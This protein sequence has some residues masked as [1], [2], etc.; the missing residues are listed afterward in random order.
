ME[1]EMAAKPDVPV[2]RV[3]ERQ[4]AQTHALILESARYLFDTNGFEKTTIRAVATHA[5][6]GLGTLYK[7]FTNKTSLLAAALYDDLERLFQK[8]TATIPS[9]GTLSEQ[10]LHMA[11]FTYRYYTSRPRLSREYLKNIVFVEDEWADKIE[12]FDRAFAE[13]VTSLSLAARERGEI[14]PEKECHYLALS[15]MADYF[16]VLAHLFLRQKSDDAGQMLDLLEKM[17]AQ[18]LS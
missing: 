8:A 9:Q 15:L 13:N 6:I 12:A 2:G 7:H 17:M 3:R 16:F 4:K 5:E 18:T 11:G 14:G 10:L 1:N